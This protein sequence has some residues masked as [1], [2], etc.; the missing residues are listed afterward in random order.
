[1][2]Y[3]LITGGTSGIGFELA[4]CF[5]RGNYGVIIVSSNKERLSVAKNNL[6]NDY[7]V[8]ILIFEQDLSKV[9]AASELYNKIRTSGINVDVL[10]NNAGYGL[11]GPTETI[12]L[13]EDENLMMLNVVSL[14]ELSKL[15]LSDMYKSGSGKI[16]NVASI[17]A[18]Q[19]GPYTATY[20][21][22]KAFVLS[23]SRAIRYEVKKSGV[24][25]CVLCPGET[26]TN[27]FSRE[28]LQ[29]PRNAMSAEDVAQYAYKRLIA[30]KEISISGIYNRITKVLPVKLKMA[31]IAKKKNHDCK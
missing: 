28:G 20:C 22:S 29:T 30:N 12:D 9:G 8:P 19:P 18:F 14:V 15:F 11:V 17:G 1:M 4:R 2:E 7:K 13:Q 25:I 31:H 10:V 26:R 6:E 5:A 23:Y 27:F 3:V 16:L 21:A 24:Q